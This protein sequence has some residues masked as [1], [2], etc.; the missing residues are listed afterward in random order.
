MLGSIL[1]KSIV[2]FPRS[3]VAILKYGY[4]IISGTGHGPQSGQGG[5]PTRSV[6]TKNGSPEQRVMIRFNL[7][8]DDS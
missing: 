6:G 7:F 2:S 4:A 3:R 1:K 5:I 8:A